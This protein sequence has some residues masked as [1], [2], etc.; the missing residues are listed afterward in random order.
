MKSLDDYDL[1]L[2]ALLWVLS[3]VLAHTCAI[4]RLGLLRKAGF[5]TRSWENQEE[6]RS[7]SQALQN[8][9]QGFLSYLKTAFG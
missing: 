4:P 8:L 6:A 9:E 1:E 7:Q 3:I 2:L 5:G